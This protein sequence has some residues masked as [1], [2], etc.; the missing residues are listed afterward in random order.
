M[1]Y[2]HSRGKCFFFCFAFAIFTASYSG[3]AY[4]QQTADSQWAPTVTEPKFPQGNGPTVLV[5]AAHGNFHT[6]DGRFA[7][8][9]GL[10]K[11]D[12]Y[13]VRSADV[14]VSTELLDQAA[15]F[16]ISN[17]IYGGDDAEWKLPTPP[18]FTPEEIA[19]IVD[20]VANGGSLLLI[21]DHMPFPGAT[22]DLANEFGIIF[23][24]GYAK[25]SLNRGGSLSF[26]RSSGALA[27]HVVTRGQSESE[28]IESVVSFTGQAFRFVS[29]V[30][31]LLHMPDDWEVFLPIKAGEFNESTPAVSASGLIQGGVLQFGSGRVA[32][33]G[34]AAM[35]TAQ[36]SV[37]D[38][39]V[40]RMGMNHAAATENAQFVLNVMHW[41]TGLLDN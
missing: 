16:V 34:E 15:I 14:E 11:L 30:Q 36:T 5:D 6:L 13:R 33:F 25:R 26:T 7:A 24:N 12:G 32:V 40:R 20:W 4:S 38:G 22:A 31:P 8:F 1:A 27:D 9:G 18:A 21:A 37:R 41:L 28:K 23:L 29:A 39:V 17:A 35:F 3:Y 19:V 10:L 2:L